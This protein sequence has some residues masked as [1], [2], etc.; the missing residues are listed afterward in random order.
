[1]PEIVVSGLGVTSAVGQGKA[2]FTAAL[3]E[4][5]HRFDVMRRPG[6]Q[7]LPADAA[8]GTPATAFLG[9][10]IG[11][12]QLPEA[13]PAQLLRTA[14]WPSRVAAATLHEAWHDAHLEQVDPLRIGLVVGGSNFQQRELVNT[15][16]AQA[17][18]F[19]FL[20]PSYGMSFMDSDLCGICTELFGIRAFAYTLGA[21]SASG[22]A[23]VI[24]AIEAV[25]SG[26][27]DVCIA[28]GALMDLSSWECQGF[29]SMGAMGSDRYA[30]DPAAACR[31]FDLQRD[32]FIF[33]ECCAALVVERADGL[34]RRVARPYARVAG[35]AMQMDGNR[36]P[37]PSL[38]GEM[39]VIQRCLA[40]AGLQ[41]RQVDYVNPHGS[42][43]LVGDE[44][45]LQAIERSGLA[46]ARLNTTKSIT[47]H[48]LTAAGAVEL[49]ATLLQMQQ[50]RLHP[51]RN[52]HQPIGLAD[53][54]VRE[55]A[56]VH[57][58]RNA[59]KL[60]MGFGGV[61]TAV[62]LQQL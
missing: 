8:A 54:F 23:A 14:S 16:V 13:L 50:G 53:N 36:N 38:E 52:L 48:G 11:T 44:T 28:L 10:E 9:A 46:G 7:W 12:L 4:G 37:N 56:E 41:P 62:C 30:A 20:R 19:A 51:S 18:R 61:N 49:A 55:R 35:W 2:D 25:R 31:P 5:H 22:Q 15:Q 43:S 59:L 32:G 24:Q 47:G 45:E 34:R 17:S 57:A 40:Q 1:M 21:A 58:V 60:S 39:A 3:M 6:R 33:G 27:A 42:G 26:Q 29:R